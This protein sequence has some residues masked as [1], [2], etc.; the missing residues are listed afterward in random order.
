[1]KV[2]VPAPVPDLAESL[3][4]AVAAASA[5]KLASDAQRPLARR[6]H[7]TVA[8]FLGGGRAGGGSGSTTSSSRR[9]DLVRSIATPGVM[10]SVNGVAV[11]RD[12]TKL[13]VADCEGDSHA[14]HEFSVADGNPLRVIG[15]FGEGPLQ[16]NSPSQLCVSPDDF[17]YVA[18]RYNHRVQV[19]TPARE[20][21]A[22]IGVDEL[23]GPRGVC[24]NDD[25]VVVSEEKACRITV[26]NRA[27]GA[28][29]RR[30]GSHGDNAGQLR[31]AMGMC[32]MPDGRHIVVTECCT[33]RLSVFNV[34]GAF[35]RHVGVGVLRICVGV[36]CTA[37]GE[38]VVADNGSGRVVVL[39]PGGKVLAT[40]SGSCQCI[41]K[42][43]L[44]GVAVHGGSIFAQYAHWH[45]TPVCDVFNCQ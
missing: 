40:M 8:G 21:H 41:G 23:D 10:S 11:S 32:F 25:V 1:M 43:R 29:L 7:V 17:L 16:F 31:H 37:D 30:F 34:S 5:L 26:F 39:S 33:Y 45:K 44:T 2:P 19:L 42:A 4:S 3:A 15:G 24:V 38:F 6:Y 14:I 35:V 28:V 20:F 13:L 22:F 36:A 27:D 9:G 18:E 12:G